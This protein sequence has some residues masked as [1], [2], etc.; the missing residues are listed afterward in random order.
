MPVILGKGG[1]DAVPEDCGTAT[2]SDR[3]A[4]SPGTTD[5][6][7][8][9]FALTHDPLLSTWFEPP[10]ARQELDPGPEQLEQLESQV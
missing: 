3:H 6:L 7:L 1:R 9:Q 8:P 5:V 2:N 4:P 10:Q